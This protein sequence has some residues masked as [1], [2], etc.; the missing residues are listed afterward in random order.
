M[1]SPLT[2]DERELLIRIDENVKHLKEE[3][4]GSADR[5][6]RLPAIEADVEKLKK[7]SWLIR[8]A[9]GLATVLLGAAEYLL[10]RKP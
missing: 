1:E 7:Q 4:L 10:H 3:I 8:G 2:N 6:G 9:G 5:E